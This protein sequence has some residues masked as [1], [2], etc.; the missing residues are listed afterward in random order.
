MRHGVQDVFGIHLIHGHFRI[1]EGSAMF[2]VELAEVDGMKGCWTKPL[3]AKDLATQS[4]HGHIYRL[5]SEGTFVPYEFRTGLA[6]TA[7]TT[8]DPAFFQEVAHFLRNHGLQ[9]LLGLELLDRPQDQ[10]SMEL[11]LGP[12]GT[13][14][15][16][17]KDL[18]SRLVS[19]GVT[20]WSFKVGEQGIISCN[21]GTEHAGTVQGTHRVFVSGKPPPTTEALQKALRKEGIII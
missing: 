3:P 8:T 13:V 5:Q 20:S 2:E 17:R 9:D 4:V 14:L 7:A 15:M 12:Q 18:T 19:Y 10:D 16:E 21:G 6:G 1:P 11:V